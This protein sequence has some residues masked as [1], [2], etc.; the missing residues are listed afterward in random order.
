MQIAL[1]VYLKSMKNRRAATLMHRTDAWYSKVEI[2]EY[3]H[4]IGKSGPTRLLGLDLCLKSPAVQ[5]RSKSG[6]C[7]T[8]QR[9]Q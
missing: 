3:S 7:S 1:F 8:S 4:R 9:N 6:A 2:T 5:T